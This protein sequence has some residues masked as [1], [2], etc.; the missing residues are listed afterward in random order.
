M[1]QGGVNTFVRTARRGPQGLA[2]IRE[3]FGLL[4]PGSERNARS[5]AE[6][7]KAY[8]ATTAALI[9]AETIANYAN[10]SKY[11][12]NMNN[13]TV[14]NLDGGIAALAPTTTSAGVLPSIKNG[15]VTY[16]N[17][18]DPTSGYSISGTLIVYYSRL[19]FRGNHSFVDGVQYDL[20]SL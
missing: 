13:V 3:K 19:R 7:R 6:A 18:Y 11:T 9:S 14:P 20:N 15:T 1:K 8:T 10:A 16:T 5:I 12:S 4:P 17:W 2:Q